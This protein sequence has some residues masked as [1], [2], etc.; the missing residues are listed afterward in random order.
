MSDQSARADDDGR[1]GK[2][3]ERAMRWILLDADPS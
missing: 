3:I 1:G 2:S